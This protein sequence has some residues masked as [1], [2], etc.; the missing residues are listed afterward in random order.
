MTE[1][2]PPLVKA[3]LAQALAADR[4]RIVAAL[5][6]RLSDLD[7]AEEAL[8]DAAASALLHWGRSGIP[9][10]PDAWLIRVAFRKAID[11]IR[12]RSRDG[13]GAAALAILA[14]DEAKEPEM[15]ADDR[16]RLIFTCCHPALDRKSSVALTL[17]T[18]CGLSTAEI[19]RAF[20][21]QEPTLGQRLSRAKAKIRAAA[22][23]YRVPD[24]E[25]WP[26][27]LGAVLAVVYLIF[28]AGYQD[29]GSGSRDL[30]SEAIYLVRMLDQLRP[31]EPEV[32]GALALMLLTHARRDARIGADGATVP[33]AD[34]NRDLWDHAMLS[35]GM[36]VLNHALERGQPGP[37]QIKAAIAVCHMLPP[38][39]DWSQILSLYDDLLALEPTPVVEV[40]RAVALAETGALSGALADL[41]RLAVVLETYQPFHA[42]QAELLVRA[43]DPAALAAYDRAIALADRSED[44]LFLEKRK[45]RCASPS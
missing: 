12:Q 26:E 24:P 16:L 8:Q 36:T 11:R 9:A 41:E 19:A 29:G 38:T 28:N 42:A 14:E 23:P 13:A 6:A 30:C 45:Q 43:G 27:R 10:R 4:G 44:V 22:I 1:A 20:L 35:E 18:I 25:D 33:P 32:E 39:P 37:C 21:D 31:G 7:L 17:R 2:I 40:N 3:A 5:M 34:Q 15:F